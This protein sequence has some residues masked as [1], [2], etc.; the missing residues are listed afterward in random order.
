M[1]S[2]S[3][4]SPAD[5]SHDDSDNGDL[6]I[7]RKQVERSRSRRRVSS[8]TRSAGART[9]RSSSV[10]THTDARKKTPKKE[11]AA[12]SCGACGS[13]SFHRHH[14]GLDLCAECYKPTRRREDHLDPGALEFSR[15]KQVQR[16]PEAR[17]Q[18]LDQWKGDSG[19]PLG[20]LK[21]ALRP[22]MEERESYTGAG[23]GGE[24]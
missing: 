23:A 19:I 11:E 1:V 16:T 21:T 9:T 22:E 13:A 17:K 20:L 14:H 4:N 15:Q 18:E 5:T 2:D 12:V 6:E 8:P 10:R 7:G 24:G 3:E